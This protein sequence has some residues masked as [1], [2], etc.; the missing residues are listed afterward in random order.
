MSEQQEDIKFLL[1][2]KDESGNSYRVIFPYISET[3]DEARESMIANAFTTAVKI[4][5]D[6]TTTETNLYVSIDFLNKPYYAVTCAIKLNCYYP[7]CQ[8][9]DSN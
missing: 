6:N 4:N 1:Y 9:S 2:L 3:T 5:S 8:V 7:I